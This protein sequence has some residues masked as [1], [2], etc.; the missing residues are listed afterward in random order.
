MYLALVTLFLES[1]PNLKYC[2]CR[3]SNNVGFN[4]LFVRRYRQTRSQFVHV[5]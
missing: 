5:R 3:E 2:V 1:Q 4:R